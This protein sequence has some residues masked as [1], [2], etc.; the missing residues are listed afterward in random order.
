MTMMDSIQNNSHIHC[1]TS[2][3]TLTPLA[4]TD[5]VTLLGKDINN[6]KKQRKAPLAFSKDVS[7]SRNEKIMG[8]H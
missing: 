4:Y 1:T 7:L 3:K 2:S 8:K 6:T 5:N